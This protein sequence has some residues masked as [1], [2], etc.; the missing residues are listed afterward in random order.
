M[1][2]ATWNVNSL[3]ARMVRVEEWLLD[4]QP[5]VVCMQETKMAEDAFPTETFAAMGYESVH[6]G[7]GQW[8]GVAILSRVGLE[9]PIRNFADGQEPDP[10]A[11]LVTATCAG[12]R[13]SSVYVPNG[14]ELDHDHYKYK[15]AWMKRLIDHLDADT[16]PT[17][18]VIVT[19][20]YNIAPEDQDVYNPADFVGA[21]HVSEAERQV[22]RDLEAWGM[23]DVFRHHHS[24]DKLYSWWDY[25]A[26]GFNQNKGMRI[27]LILAT[28]SVLEKTRWTIVD[29]QARKGE[30]PSDHA[31]VLVDIDV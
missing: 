11:R 6:H 25:R 15:L 26:G 9:N 14:R 5:D 12:I 21:T 19:G 28:Q 13:V 2:L 20:D 4:V 16:S 17:Q 7:Q 30:K 3:R 22:L 29:R 31:P 24:D 1:R 27:D 8:N 18:G 10:E 23:S